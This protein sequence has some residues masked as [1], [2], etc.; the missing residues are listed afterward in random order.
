MADQARFARWSGDTN[1]MHMDPA[2]ARRT[3]AGAPAVHGVHA[4]LWA[5]DQL[6][7]ER[8]IA[9]VSAR[10]EKF[11]TV[12][13][14]IELRGAEGERSA[15]LE[16]RG[17]NART[18]AIT[19]TYG[20]PRA[21]EPAPAPDAPRL[22]EAATPLGFDQ[23]KAAAGAFQMVEADVRDVFPRLVARCGAA[24]VQG[25]MALS[26]LVG[27]VCPGLHSIFSSLSAQLLETA[28]AAPAVLVWRTSS[29]HD[30]F[31]LVAMEARA[32]GLVAEVE[33][34]MRPAPVEQ[35]KLKDLQAQVDPEV[36][37]GVR[38]LIIGGSRGIGEVTAKLLA[39]GGAEVAIT[40]ATGRAEAEVLAQE[41]AGRGAKLEVSAFDARQPAPPQ[42]ADLPFRPTHVFYF[43]TSKIFRQKSGLYGKDLLDEFN[44]IYVTAF[45]DICQHFSGGAPVKIFYP[46]SVAVEERPRDMTEYAMAKAAGEVLCDDIDRF[47]AG[48][49]IVRHRLPRLATDQ[50]ATVTAVE[51]VSSAEV[52]KAIIDTVCAGPPI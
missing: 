43:A 5:L 12:D 10:F 16:L 33:A 47:M 36:Y 6:P 9:K 31:G 13:Q 27:M 51:N 34:F 32:P 19:V 44:Q 50:T 18:A 23:A 22:P 37:H 49:H 20:S 29:S 17:P 40:Y 35:P 41:F 3:Q 25:L 8:P 48:V 42:L 1:P 14:R 2:A 39:A 46:S 15:K 7:G 45:F 28:P 11:M 4:L 52:M 26:S 21:A 30:A 38:A 24:P